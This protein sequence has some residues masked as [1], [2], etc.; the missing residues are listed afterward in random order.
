[1]QGQRISSR[2]E[3]FVAAMRG[4]VRKA[5]AARLKPEN[6][7][8]ADRL[9]WMQDRRAVFQPDGSAQGRQ[10]LEKAV[11]TKGS[12]SWCIERL[13]LWIVLPSLRRCGLLLLF[14]LVRLCLL[15]TLALLL[16]AHHVR[17]GEIDQLAW[18]MVPR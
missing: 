17:H 10:R 2:L 13:H 12:H 1:M 9:H 8:N 15:C 3:S 16:D 11:S 7:A 14:L 4:I 5:A 18:K 6:G